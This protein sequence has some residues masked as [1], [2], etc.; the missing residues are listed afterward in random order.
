MTARDREALEAA[1]ARLF[2]H[3]GL[4]W[5]SRQLS[6]RD[7]PVEH[8]RVIEVG[9][10]PP[11][12]F[13]HGAGMCAAIWA[14]L[15]VHLAGR[16]AICVD[17][18]GCGLTEPFDHRGSDLRTHGRTFLA[19]VAEA[20]GV[21][22][23]PVVANSLGATHTLYLAA[24]RPDLVDSIM[25]LGAPGVAIA[26]GR[27]NTA[28]RLYSRPALARA[29]SAVT[30]PMNARM[31]RRV[32]A[33]TCGTAAVDTVPEAMFD[34]V[35]AAMRIS[36]PTMR[37]LVPGL[38]DRGRTRP[39]LALTD[40]EWATVRAPTLFVWGRHD[41]FQSLAAAADLVAGLSGVDLVEVPGGHHP[42]WDDPAGCAG[43]IDQ[44]LS[45]V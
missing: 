38:F 14:P 34:V 3:L 5:Q 41:P 25:L 31:A 45:E 23:L 13:V 21:G 7:A 36:E 17:L 16:R 4:A 37:T 15:L 42:W 19:A 9:D 27:A 18:P 22:S 32:L 20:V 30:P 39:D 26:G 44:H 8:A 10:G 33:S 24:E 35:A 6:L 28:M 29:M 2:D 43:L 12:L 11:V 1:E 40:D